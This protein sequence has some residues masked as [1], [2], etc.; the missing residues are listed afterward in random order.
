MLGASA[1]RL[2][3]LPLALPSEDRVSHALSA[4]SLP[5][6]SLGAFVLAFCLG[7]GAAP[8]QAS[9]GGTPG[10]TPASA[11]AWQAGDCYRCHE[12]PGATAAVSRLDS[13][14]DCHAWIRE[15][16][17]SPAK[18]EKAMGVFPLWERYERNTRSYLAVPPLDAAMARLDPDWVGD[19]L[20][21]PHDLRP[22]MSETMPRFALSEAQR[23]ALVADFA[24]AAVAVP[25]TP[26]PDPAHVDEGLA[27]LS[28]KAC[29]TCHA[30]GAAVPALV[31]S[32][33]PDLAHARSRLSPD[34]A[35]A[36][37]R[38]PQAISPGATMPAMGL[39][40]AEAVSIRY[41]L[42][43]ADPAWTEA[44]ALGPAPR[45]AT[46]PVTY[47]ELEEKVF[48]KIRV[49]CHMDPAQNQGRAGPGNAGG[50]G[51]AATG[52]ELQTM[53]GVR[54]VADKLPRVLLDRRAE[55]HR[56]VVSAGQRPAALARPERPGMPLGLPPIPDEDIALVL[57]WIDQ[58]MPE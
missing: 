28:A 38:N 21:D 29:T 22:G 18:R 52:I 49:H 27:L 37:M 48:G 25:A 33:A 16:A 39:S 14:A 6:A 30:F 9:T 20:A 56:D 26:A 53:D 50:F 54:A 35:V 42:W 32:H 12:V 5:L 34:M 13:C 40:E 58:G 24:A 51:Y 19:Y 57:A 44:P 7:A 15:V 43:L 45:A 2:A 17:S 55:A 10:A 36:W 46:R 8:V 3:L 47:A 41:A 4:L 1:T 11:D 31:Q 23:A